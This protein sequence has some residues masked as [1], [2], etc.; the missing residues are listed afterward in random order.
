M[1]HGNGNVNIKLEASLIYN[2]FILIMMTKKQGHEHGGNYHDHETSEL[3][4]TMS[5]V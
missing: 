1:S 2:C 4:Q 5:V 3:Q